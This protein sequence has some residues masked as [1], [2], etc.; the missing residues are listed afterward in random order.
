MYTEFMIECKIKAD[1]RPSF[2][3]ALRVIIHD[4]AAFFG[5]ANIAIL[6]ECLIDPLARA[7][8]DHPRCD[9]MANPLDEA[10][11]LDTVLGYNGPWSFD[12]VTLKIGTEVKNYDRVIDKFWA[13]V[14]PWIDEPEG[15]AIGECMYEDCVAPSPVVVG[16]ELFHGV[17]GPI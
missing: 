15:T 9:F 14:S 17:W 11:S 1:A 10:N 2:K 7:F 5:K 4:R 6:D 12:G 8:F 13:W 3:E 16:G